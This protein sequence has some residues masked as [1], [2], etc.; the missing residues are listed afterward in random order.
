MR[1]LLSGHTY[2]VR[3]EAHCTLTRSLER[4]GGIVKCIPVCTGEPTDLRRRESLDYE[5]RGGANR[6][7]ENYPR[8][9]RNWGDLFVLDFQ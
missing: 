1:P 5:H 8:R 9:S 7:L 3:A 2:R 6:A 4:L